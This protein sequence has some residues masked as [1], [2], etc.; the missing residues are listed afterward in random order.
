VVEVVRRVPLLDAAFAHDADHVG[1]GE[2]FVLVV[3]D[4]D[5]RHPGAFEDVAHFQRQ[6]FAQF[7]VEVGKGLVEQQQ[8]RLRR[9]GAGQGH[10]LLLATRKFVRIAFASIAQADQFE[11]FFDASPSRRRR[12]FTQAEADVV[13]NGQMREQRIVLEHHANASGLGGKLDHSIR[14]GLAVEAD[15]ARIGRL[16]SRDQAQ[17]GGLAAA[18]GTKQA[19]DFAGLQGE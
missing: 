15:A 10:A 8:V 18:G 3:R 16:E 12:L 2:G 17:H 5:R 6:A 13:G 7:D 9:Q 4:Q 14:D 19:G 11:H 1:D